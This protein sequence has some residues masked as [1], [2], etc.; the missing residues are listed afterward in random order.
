MTETLLNTSAILLF[1]R[2]VEDLRIDPNASDPAHS[3]APGH[4]AQQLAAK[5]P[6]LARV[7]G[8]GLAGVYHL[9]PTPALFL[10]HGPGAPAAT[11]LAG[12]NP[13][14][15]PEAGDKD[16]APVPAGA[17]L[18]EDLVAWSYDKADYT[19]RLDVQT[20]SSNS[21]C[22]AAAPTAPRPAG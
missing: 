16:R 1:G 5:D 2:V 14:S 15:P 11:L 20:G 7:Y 4:L 6:R 9:L 18:P 13:S 19:I 22:W 12:L 3:G 8:F 17:L 10:V 21:S